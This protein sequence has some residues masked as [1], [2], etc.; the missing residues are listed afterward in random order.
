MASGP[1]D[2]W[3]LCTVTEHPPLE[4]RALV[5]DEGMRLGSL[6]VFMCF[7]PLQLRARQEQETCWV[8]LS[9]TFLHS[10]VTGLESLS[11]QKWW[12]CSLSWIQGH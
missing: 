8:V 5:L 4:G 6:P 12:S 3:I 9:S 2:K 11:S 10:P 1:E 7:I